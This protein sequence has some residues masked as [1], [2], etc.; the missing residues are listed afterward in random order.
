MRRRD[1]ITF[2]GG[3]AA[4]VAARGAGAAPACPY[5]A[6][7]HH[8]QRARL[9]QLPAGP[10]RSRLHREPE[11]RHRI[12]ICGREGRS[13]SSGC[14][15]ARL[16]PS[17]CDRR[18]RFA[19]NPRSP[20]DDLDDS[21]RGDRGRRPADSRLRGQPCAT[22]G[23]YDRVVLSIVRSHWQASGDSQGMRSRRGPRGVPVESGQ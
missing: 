23:K 16:G 20:A 15:R 2:L 10:A 17:R 6:H 12:S 1:F 13:S 22:G 5:A 4:G 11:H 7:R 18:H 19:S 21:D 3:A 9:G 14:T 8:R